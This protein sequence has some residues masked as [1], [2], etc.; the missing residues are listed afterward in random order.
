VTELWAGDRPVIL[1][2]FCKAGGA[3]YG[4]WLAGFDVIGVDIEPQRHYPF[5]FVQADAIEALGS[6]DLSRFAALHASPPCQSYTAARTM[7]SQQG[8]VYPDLVDVTRA[9]LA[10]SGRPW[11]ME[12]VPGSPLEAHVVLCGSMFGRQLV[13]DGELYQ[14]RRHRL[15]EVAGFWTMTPQCQHRGRALGVH[16]NGGRQR[17][18]RDRYG[19]QATHGEACAL[20]G[21]EWMTTKELCQAIPPCY[22]EY[23]GRALLDEVAY[24]GQGAT[25]AS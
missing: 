6:W 22:T 15:F 24:A 13:N 10:A 14:L 25:I 5:R 7:W 8:R 18:R 16:G 23:L 11:I 1:D 3:G 19:D 2:A 17:K 4:Y 21:I 12:N 20:M 9:G